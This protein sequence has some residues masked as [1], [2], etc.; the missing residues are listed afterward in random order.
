MNAPFKVRKWG[1][2]TS[3]V[4]ADVLSPV[5]EQAFEKLLKLWRCSPVVFLFG[6]A[7]S[8][9]TTIVRRFAEQEGADIVT[10]DDVADFMRPQEALWFDLRLMA[11]LQERLKTS[12]T[13]ILDGVLAFFNTLRPERSVTTRYAIIETLYRDAERWGKKLIVTGE[14]AE[15][16][17]TVHHIFSRGDMP[18]VSIPFF[19]HEDYATIATARMGAD[20]VAEISFSQVFRFA[21]MLNGHDLRAVSGVLAREDVPTTQGFMEAIHEFIASANTNTHEVEEVTFDTMP[22]TEEIARQ[23]ETHIITPLT[24]L[25][26]AD[27]LDLRAKR[28]VLL[29][30]P[31]G[32]GKTSVG[33]ALAHLLKG[34]FFLIDGSIR[35]E[36][37]Y[38]FLSNVQA[39]V[40]EAIENAPS[41]I[42]IDDADVL[43]DV[44]HVGGLSRYLLTLLDGLAGVNASK[45]CVMM[46][47]MDPGKIPEAILRSGRV[48]LW[49]ETRLPT[50]EIRGGIMQRWLGEGVR[51]FDE[52]DYDALASLTEGFTPADLRRVMADAKSLCAFDIVHNKPLSTGTSYA[53]RAVKDM[54]ASR[55]A[56]A[57]NL[58]DPSLRVG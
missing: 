14:P 13:L 32:T 23:L 48:E 24:D 56:M 52:V 11:W 54:I 37:A 12:Q 36:P 40:S 33:R 38:E 2:L 53:Q 18:V 9:K 4:P 41:V 5:Q 6:N 20:K 50:R 34:R 10:L 26:L 29:Y 46:T 15:Y 19:T 27:E 22:G 25:E 28:G 58:N 31:P 21:S 43:F 42:F 7:G 47:A 35:T 57:S 44:G 39:I 1:A 30:G 45:V 51:G 49:L 3:S 16:R 55:A 17:P 8:G